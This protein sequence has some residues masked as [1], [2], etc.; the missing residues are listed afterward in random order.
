MTRLVKLQAFSLT[1]RIIAMVLGLIETFVVIRVLTVSE[2]G[3]VQLAVSVGGAFGIYQHLGLASGS[4]REIAAAQ[5]DEDVPKIFFT[6]VFIRYLATIPIFAFLFFFAERIALDQYNEAAL[7]FPIRLY[8]VALLIGGSQSIL[9]SVISGT[10]RFKALFLYQAIIAFVNLCFYVPLVYFFNVNGYFYAMVAFNIVSTITL[11]FIAF[12]PYIGM[13]SLPGKKDFIRILKQ[14]VSISL[15]IY[16]VKVIYTWWE[17]SGPLLLGRDLSTEM[18]AFFAFALLYSKKLMLISD[19]ITTVNLPVLSESYVND[20]EE[21]KSTFFQ[22]FDKIFVFI[23]ASGFFAIFWCREIFYILVGGT[24]YDPAIPLVLPLM[25]AFI[26][27]S[28]VNIVESSILIPAKRVLAMIVSFALMLIVTV[29]G[30][31]LTG[32]L[33]DPMISMAYF[34]A[35]GA[36]LALCS[37]EVFIRIKLK[38]G[39]IRLGHVLLFIQI[40]AMSLPY[41]SQNIFLKL[42]LFVI[43]GLLYW[44]AVL[45]TGF[46]TNEQLV[47]LLKKGIF[48]IKGQVRQLSLR[49]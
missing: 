46:M 33:I 45:L 49:S 13:I 16:V 30:F 43:F 39:F 14:L 40:I 7:I 44:K 2:W 41:A 42:V 3:I 20:H 21:F 35:L 8:A 11:I 15:A 48:W 27:Y 1:S 10:R 36:L 9:N 4:T 24:R 23:L 38:F 32:G 17:K 6:S 18:V 31:F 25:L 5:S 29:S 34:L 22:N 37:M 47:S 26:L 19:S 12:K 28:F